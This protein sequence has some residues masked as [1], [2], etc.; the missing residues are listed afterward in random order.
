MVQKIF[1]NKFINSFVV[2]VS[3][4]PFT[5]SALRDLDTELNTYEQFFLDPAV[6]KN[7]ISKNELLASFAISKA[8][9]ST[10]TLAEAE[11]VYSLVLSNSNYSFIQKKLQAKDRL[12]RKDYEKIEFLNIITTVRKY[13]QQ[14]PTLNDVT[15]SFIQDLHKQLTQGL[16]VFATF[17]RDFTP[18]RSGQWRNN[19]TICVGSYIPAPYQEIVPCIEEILAWFKSYPTITHEG[20]FHTLLYAVHP[21]NN[22]NKRVARVLEHLL[23][24]IIGLN[25]KN[26]YSTS[27]YYH[28]EKARYYKYL[29]YSLEKKNLNYFTAFFQEAVALSIITVVQSGLEVQRLQF[30]KRKDVPLF[31]KYI[32]HAFVKRRE[33]QFGTLLRLVHKKMAKQ[34]FVNHLQ[35]ATADGLIIRRQVGKATYYRLNATFKEEAILD[36]LLGRITAIVPYVPDSIKLS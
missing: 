9:N 35:Q 29:L 12:T 27:Y 13:N 20:I 23:L 26:L 18:Y 28:Q 30:I 33:L 6:E 10:L 31:T 5:D 3:L 17:L 8:E 19:D 7:L 15:L 16:D 2:D 34:S 22:G 21:F 4:L 25:S 11:E 24:R 1:D 32:L 14:L 36:E